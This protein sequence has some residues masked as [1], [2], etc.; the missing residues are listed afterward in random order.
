MAVM[1][2]R[3]V[4]YVYYEDFKA[5]GFTDICFLNVL[6]SAQNKKIG[7]KLAKKAI[8]DSFKKSE[9]KK[10]EISVRVDNTKAFRLYQRLGF[11]ETITYLA[12]ELKF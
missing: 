2:D 7:T 8:E 4:G 10:I 3:V 1:D 5:D 9:I 12:Y 11:K 6:Q